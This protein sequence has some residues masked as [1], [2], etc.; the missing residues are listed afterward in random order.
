LEP[1][2]WALCSGGGSARL[3]I[4][5]DARPLDGTFRPAAQPVPRDAGA[6]RR[7]PAGTVISAQ[8]TVPDLAIAVELVIAWRRA[9]LL[10]RRGAL[11]PPPDKGEAQ[12]AIGSV[13]DATG[14]DGF[15]LSPYR[16]NLQQVHVRDV[17]RLRATLRTL[18]DAVLNGMGVQQYELQNV[19]LTGSASASLSYSSLASLDILAEVPAPLVHGFPNAVHIGA[20]LAMLSTSA[21]AEITAL[22]RRTE[23]LTLSS[24]TPTWAEGLYL[25]LVADGRALDGLM[26]PL[27]DFPSPSWSAGDRP[28]A[29]R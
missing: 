4:A 2:P 24:G 14:V 10:D 9:G 16:D 18:R 5:P 26:P 20:Q 22:A 7:G 28:P 13:K 3:A 29:D 15:H 8:R 25:D 21:A 23:L 27:L 11:V 19:A 12:N 1:Y 6:V 17:Q